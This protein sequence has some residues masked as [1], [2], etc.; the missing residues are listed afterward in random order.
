MSA[1]L[2]RFPWLGLAYGVALWLFA[3][4][5]FGMGEGTYHLFA[6]FGAPLS[7][8]PILGLF[9]PP[10]WWP[11]TEFVLRRHL[12]AAAVVMLLSHC[13]VAWFDYRSG[14]MESGDDQWR[15]Y[16]RAARFYGTEMRLGVALYLIGLTVTSFLTVRLLE[17]KRS[18]QDAPQ[19]GR[20]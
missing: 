10:V 1:A 13:A 9:A 7:A 12:R 2:R 11:A 4:A 16:E 17:S 14:I 3:W 18:R 8:L 19:S 15:H 5:G 20:L 6:W